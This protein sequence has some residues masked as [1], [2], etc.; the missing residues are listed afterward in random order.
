VF[1]VAAPHRTFVLAAVLALAAF[2]LFFRL[3]RE[4]VT[5][6]DESLYAI[7]AAETAA[8][9]HWIGT[10][11]RGELD[12]YNTK[13]P[14]NVWMIAA[15]FRVLGVSLLTLR[16]P[17]ALAAWMTVLVLYAWSRRAFGA[18]TAF[19]AAVVLSTTFG[20]I[21][22]HSGRSANTDA[23]FTLLL[24][25]VVVTLWS[26]AARPWRL[27]W[28]GPALAAIF[29][30]R[31]TAVLM[32][33]SLIAAVEAIAGRPLRRR[34]PPLMCAV[35]LAAIPS[36]L[37]AH[38]RW[39]LDGTVFLR[40]MVA[41]DLLARATAPLEGHHGS[42]LYY[43][44]VLQKDQYDWLLAAAAAILLVR[45]PWALARAQLG[46]WFPG[47]YR[48][49]LILGWAGITLL[50]PTVMRT[51]VAWYLNPFFPAFALLLGLLLD[52]ALT[53]ASTA[54]AWRRRTLVAAMLLAFAVAESKLIFYS[55]ARRSL[56]GSAQG[57]LLAERD[58]LRSRRIF[59][60]GWTRSGLFVAEHIVGAQAVEAYGEDD[61]LERGAPGDYMLMR[62]A[63]ADYTRLA[64]VNANRR[65]A[66]CTK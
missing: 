17:S 39:Q 44:N 25:L 4:I 14:L 15:T 12:Y 52:D 61:F 63:S 36:L 13:P 31:G 37:W 48:R 35:V 5:E 50:V 41:Y 60:A 66:L 59:R 45:P 24:L 51:K 42:A 43:L 26:A 30:L 8:H 38:A 16:L 54:A 1:R 23:P 40:R 20:F 7:S 11:F 32:P 9:G 58:R 57:L 29:L 3:D 62:S 34:L 47:A 19:L 6:W 33:I 21:Y 65:Y 56:E 10:T 55:Y 2:N 18:R 46:A 64:C 22:V 49:A 28:L 27:V 53:R